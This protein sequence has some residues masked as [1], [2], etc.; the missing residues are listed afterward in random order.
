VAA[1][2]VVADRLHRHLPP[3]L[4]VRHPGDLQRRVTVR[5]QGTGVGRNGRAHGRHDQV[6]VKRADEHNPTTFPLSGR[7]GLRLLPSALSGD[8][9]RAE[10]AAVASVPAAQFRWDRAFA[11]F[12]GAVL[13]GKD[14]R[15]AEAVAE[16]LRGVEPY[17]PAE[18][19]SAA[20]EYFRNGAVL[21]Y[22]GR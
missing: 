2:L 18:W 20:E 16:A 12:A 8:L 3:R 10:Y 14:G 11:S 5:Q 4:V 22:R 21:W 15:P 13:S 6:A 7:Y 17:P 19:R 9:D 1:E